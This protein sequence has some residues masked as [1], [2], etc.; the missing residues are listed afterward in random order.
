MDEGRANPDA[1]HGL[2][3]IAGNA[4]L[5]ASTLV[6]QPARRKIDW[7]DEVAQRSAPVTVTPPERSWKGAASLLRGNPRKFPVCL[8]ILRQ[9]F[10]L[11]RV[12]TGIDET[13]DDQMILQATVAAKPQSPN[14]VRQH[15]NGHGRAN[16]SLSEN[17]Q[18]KV[19]SNSTGTR[20]V[21]KGGDDTQYRVSKPLCATPIRRSRRPVPP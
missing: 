18:P 8:G 14:W 10:G 21:K 15:E 6:V 5:G 17:R 4:S 12:C 2:T 3:V 7:N 20:K 13:A 16:D 9:D 19:S 11:H 1:T